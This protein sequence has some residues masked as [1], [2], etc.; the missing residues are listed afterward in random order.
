[1]DKLQCK[2]PYLY[3]ENYVTYCHFMGIVLGFVSLVL[4][5]LFIKKF[6]LPVTLKLGKFSFKVLKTGF[7]ESLAFEEVFY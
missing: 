7:P 2:Q 1:M 5:F 6:H 3:G 4:M